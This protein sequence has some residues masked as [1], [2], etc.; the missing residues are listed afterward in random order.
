MT[1]HD[2]SFGYPGAGLLFDGLDATFA[3]GRIHSLLGPSGSGKTTLLYLASGLLE[4]SR[5]ELTVRDDRTGG[6]SALILQEYGLFP[7]KRVYENVSLGLEIRG[8]SKQLVAGKVEPILQELGIAH[9]AKRY[10]KAI[11]G[12]ERQ[13]VAIAR[14][15]VTEPDLLLMDEPFASL[16][17]R[18]REE[19][20]ELILRLSTH[21]HMT[22][23]LVTHSI[24]EAAYV[25]DEVHIL[26]KDRISGSVQILSDPQGAGKRERDSPGLFQSVAIIRKRLQE[27]V[28]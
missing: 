9:L 10:P 16:D 22:M 23:L 28:G 25:S 12:G 8:L 18:L 1:I 19:M 17:A 2:L 20:Q 11:S 24:E 4:P 13:R 3:E 26:S 21:H 6:R 7:W 27:A 5:G 14:A 15:L